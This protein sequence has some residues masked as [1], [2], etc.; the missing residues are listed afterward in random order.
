[1][2]NCNILTAQNI[3]SKR[4]IEVDY[5]KTLAIFLVVFGHFLECFYSSHSLL[6]YQLI[7]MFHI[8]LFV[9]ISGYLAKFKYSDLIKFGLIYLFFHLFYNVFN[10]FLSGTSITLNVFYP[11]W[12][13]WYLLSLIIWKMTVPLLDKVSD[14]YYPL[15]IISLFLIG[16]YV[17]SNTNI[18]RLFSLSRMIS[19]YPFFV[20]GYFNKKSQTFGFNLKIKNWIKLFLILIVLLI[21]ALLIDKNMF[22]SSAFYMAD[23]Y[24]GTQH[25][26]IQRTII[27][28]FAFIMIILISSVSNTKK[29]V[30]IEH[31]SKNTLTIF[32]LHGFIINLFKN[33]NILP[34]SNLSILFSIMLSIATVIVLTGIGLLITKLK[35]I[36]TNKFK[37]KNQKKSI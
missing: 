4:I 26:I 28:M 1:M 3:K 13:L 15:V 23:P 8:P 24:F 37:I 22:L 29:S 34:N 16:L 33:F 11:Y 14:K 20:L 32:L 10:F 35:T 31:I 27:Y 9:F 19:F 6:I 12:I 17:G 36:C 2:N 7:Y 18:N 21:F 30:V 25:T 5:L